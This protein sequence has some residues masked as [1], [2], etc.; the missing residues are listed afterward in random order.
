MNFCMRRIAS[1]VNAKQSGGGILSFAAL[2]AAMA[3]VVVASGC[4]SSPPIK[5]YPIHPPPSAAAPPRGDPINAGIFVPLPLTSHIYR[6][7]PIVYANDA[8]QF[9]TYETHRWVE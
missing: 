7:D 9:G 6:E 1:G 2:V 8:Y 3:F 5:Y 4:G